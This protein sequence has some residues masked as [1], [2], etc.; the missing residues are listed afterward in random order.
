MAS[1]YSRLGDGGNNRNYGTTST[2]SVDF[3]PAQQQSGTEFFQAS[4]A[5]CQPI[6]SLL[7]KIII[8]H[9]ESF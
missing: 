5:Q 3:A 4:L 2:P 7:F 6:S 9:T 8:Y 1:G